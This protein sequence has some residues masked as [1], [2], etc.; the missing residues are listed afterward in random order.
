MKK[1]ISIIAILICLCEISCS[2]FE[3]YFEK[4]ELAQI[5][6]DECLVYPDRQ[7]VSCKGTVE[8]DGG[9]N[10]IQRGICY[11]YGTG[12]PKITD[13]IASGGSGVGSFS[14][15]ITVHQ[16]GTYSYCAYATNDIGTSYGEVKT[17]YVAG[18]LDDFKGK[19]RFVGYNTSTNAFEYWSNVNINTFEGPDNGTWI[20]M[21]GLYQ[22][23]SS[24]KAVGKV[25]QYNKCIKL[26]SDIRISGTEF[27]FGDEDTVYYATFSLFAQEDGDDYWLSGGEGYEHTSEAWLSF[28]NEWN[29]CLGPSRF[30][31]NYGRYASGF[32]FRYYRNDDDS[33]CGYFPKY[34]YVKLI[35][36]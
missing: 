1:T 9:S 15:P 20:Y 5:S 30:P 33:Y 13:R 23:I 12:N 2:Y 29:L 19:Y 17:F 16:N 3:N 22:G 35:K 18:L 36:E 32:S 8:N 26:F 21:D 24:F 31:D 28:D 27:T 6:T 14:C 11:M 4:G 34:T 25:D 10:V 7:S